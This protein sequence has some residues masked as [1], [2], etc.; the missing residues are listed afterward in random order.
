MLAIGFTQ[1][2][3]AGNNFSLAGG[4][5]DQVP[6]VSDGQAKFQAVITFVE[7]PQQLCHPS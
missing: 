1:A 4:H 7:M 6:K 3:S 5:V 2:F